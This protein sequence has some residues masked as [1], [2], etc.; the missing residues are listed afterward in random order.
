HG[1]RT[2]AGPATRHGATLSVDRHKFAHW[3]SRGR[4][5]TAAAAGRGAGTLSKTA[6]ATTT[7]ATGRPTAPANG[8]RGRPGPPADR[9]GTAFHVANGVAA[10]GW[11]RRFCPRAAQRHP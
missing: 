2:T 11:P 7:A 5:D 3:R 4:S 8:E 1:R 10:D 6:A 9:G